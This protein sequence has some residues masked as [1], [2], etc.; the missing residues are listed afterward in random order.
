MIGQTMSGQFTIFKWAAGHRTH[1]KYS[2]TDADPHNV[3]RGFMFSHM[4][5]TVMREHPMVE[6][7]GSTIDFSD[8]LADPVVRIQKVTRFTK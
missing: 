1:H 6:I 4:G 3:R 2:D 5:W 7:K 8:L